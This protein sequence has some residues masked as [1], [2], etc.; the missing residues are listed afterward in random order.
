MKIVTVT[1]LFIF[2][3]SRHSDDTLHGVKRKIN[4]QQERS[5]NKLNKLIR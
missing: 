4:L 1:D 5:T 3:L 2:T